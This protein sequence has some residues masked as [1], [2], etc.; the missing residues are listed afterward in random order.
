[1][2]IENL[3]NGLNESYKGLQA[4]SENSNKLYLGY[5]DYH[6][7]LN[8]VFSGY[9]ELNQKLQPLPKELEN[10]Y[11][12]HIQLVGGLDT[13]FQGLNSMDSGISEI[14]NNT[15]ALPNKVGE[16]AEGGQEELTKGMSKLNNEG[17]IKIK[18]TIEIFTRNGGENEKENYTS[19]VDSGNGN[20]STCQFIMKTP[21]IKN[22][23]A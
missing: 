3:S 16:L 12:G 5:S 15:K 11:N 17:M 1:M 18:D 20:N 4:I 10:M 6:K 13:L 9:N 7:G 8:E 21:A 22:R 19:F 14:N 23:E 2:T